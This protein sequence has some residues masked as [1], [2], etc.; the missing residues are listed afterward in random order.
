MGQI[1]KENITLIENTED[2]KNIKID[3]PTDYVKK[4][5]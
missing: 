2:A 3:G 5:T 4:T 1:P